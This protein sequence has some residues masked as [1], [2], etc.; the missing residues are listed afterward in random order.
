VI[1][2]FAIVVAAVSVPI[3]G[4]SLGKLAA[5][6][7][8]GRWAIALALGLQVLI[9]SVFPKQM[10]GWP[11][12]IVELACYLLAMG[13]LVINR[14]T[15]WLWLVGIGGL[16][17]LIA[18]GAN[19]G[20]MPASPVALR[21]AGRIRHPG[22]F[23]NSTSL[24]H[25]HLSF[26]GDNF[27]VPRMLPL[28][29]VFSVGDVILAVGALLLLHS[30]CSSAPATALRRLWRE[31]ELSR[32][33]APSEVLVR[34][35]GVGKP[36]SGPDAHLELSLDDPIEQL[37]APSNELVSR[38]GVVPQHRAREVQRATHLQPPHL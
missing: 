38:H 35:G 21:A 8:N 12:Q 1:L 33:A 27:S 24:A 3:C 15:P 28:A 13:F 10:R 19:A 9:I 16:C 32:A 11:G 25:P 20:V 4:G 29:N 22:Q 2:V 37:V 6:E 34:L 7:I 5:L 18:I 30:V 23:M 31:K 17:N 14:R 36:V 26:L